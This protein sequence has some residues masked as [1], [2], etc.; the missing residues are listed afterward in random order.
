MLTHIGPKVWLQIVNQ[1]CVNK[2]WAKSVVTDR[3]F[4]R[5]RIV[6]LFLRRW[7]IIE[8]RIQLSTTYR[9]PTDVLFYQPWIYNIPVAALDT[10]AMVSFPFFSS[11]LL[12]DRF[13]VLLK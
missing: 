8:Y 13:S 1:N 5:N 12:T 11:I 2:Y 7:L 4:G 10:R 3:S 6:Q 9:R